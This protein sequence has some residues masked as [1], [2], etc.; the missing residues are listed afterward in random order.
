MNTI[1]ICTRG[2][3]KNNPGPAAIGVY[4]TDEK[5]EMIVEVAES[6]GNATSGYAEYFAVVRGLQAV[7]ERF[8][9]KTT[10]MHFELR[11]ESELVDNHLQAKAEIK[12]VSLIGHFIEIYNM[13]VASFPNLTHTLVSREDNTDADRL[14]SGVLDA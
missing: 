1:I 14:V 7:Q 12:D 9:D 5:G 11:Q 2:A 8:G 6:I 13:R 10:D 3:S 4:V